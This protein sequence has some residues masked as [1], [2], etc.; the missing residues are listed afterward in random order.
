MVAKNSKLYSVTDI[1]SIRD[2]LSELPDVTQE[3]LQKVD[4]L[5]SLK[6][7]I[8]T[9]I[10]KK[11]YTLKEILEH[12]KNFGFQDVT[13]KD[14]KEITEGKKTRQRKRGSSSTVVKT[15]V[16]TGNVPSGS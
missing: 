1:E 7:D 11:G 13:L 16:Q 6:M 4:V 2:Q 9:L 12:L 14:L 10:N 15:Q 5:D 3:R 8:E